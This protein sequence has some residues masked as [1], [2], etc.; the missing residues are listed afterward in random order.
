MK[1]MVALSRCQTGNTY[2]SI[3]SQDGTPDVVMFV[4]TSTTS[5]DYAYAITNEAN[6]ILTITSDAQFDFDVA[7]TGICRIWGFSYNG[8]ILAE[9]G[10]SVFTTRFSEGCWEISTTA[11]TVNRTG[12]DGG[13][14][15]MPSGATVRYTCPGDGNDD[16]VMFTH[17]TSTPNVNYAYV[18]T[19]DQNN[20]LGLPPGNSQNFEGAGVGVCR[21]WGCVY[22]QHHCRA[23]D[24]AAAVDLS[25]GCFSLSS[26]FIEIIRDNPGRRDCPN[27]WRRNGCE[28]LCR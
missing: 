3:C 13:M 9:P 12:V 6:E 15:A 7:P 24:N 21:V 26:N 2:R 17:E 8:D 10:E 18:I 28:Y 11:I 22:G 27:Y 16:V 19:D 4:N 5:A 23:G 1:S 20:I 14:V 25:D